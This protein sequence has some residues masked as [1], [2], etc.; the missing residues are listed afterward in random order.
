MLRAQVISQQNTQTENQNVV[1]MCHIE[2]YLKN[3]IKIENI[4]N[5]RYFRS[6]ISMIY[7]GDIYR[8][9]PAYTNGPSLRTQYGSTS[10]DILRHIVYKTVTSTLAGWLS[11]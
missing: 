9:N 6:K 5:I 1:T 4:E 3:L 7:I 2:K 8:A 10:Q 11:Q